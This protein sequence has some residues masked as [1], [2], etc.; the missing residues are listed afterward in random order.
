[1]IAYELYSFDPEG[2][3]E[4]IGM[5]PERRK[6]PAR[7]TPESVIK[8]GRRILGEKADGKKVL[9]KQVFLDEKTGEIHRARS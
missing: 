6:N 4:F 8:W 7:R 9:F 3:Y 2:G 1:M 5:L